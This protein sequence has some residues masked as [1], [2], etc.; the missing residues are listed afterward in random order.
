MRHL[1]IALTFMLPGKLFSQWITLSSG[2][3]ENLRSIYFINSETGYT[4]GEYGKMYRTVNGGNSWDTINT[5][6]NRDINSVYFFNESEGIACANEGIIIRTANAGTNWISVS[7]GVTGNLYSVSF[8]DTRGVCAGAD[9]TLLYST[10]SGLSWTIAKNGFFVIYYAAEMFSKSISYAAGVNT[11]FQPFVAKSTNGGANWS[12][13]NFYL[14]G[15][16]GDLYDINFIN[17]YTGFAPSGVF[18]GQGGIS[19]TTDGG[20]SWSTQLFE[21]QLYSIDFAGPNTGYCV[22]LQG[23]ILKTT[24]GGLTW[25]SQSGTSGTLRSVIF[26]DSLT[27]Y[28]AGDLGVI[29]K[30]TNG[31]LTAVS[32]P[33]EFAPGKYSLKQNYP[34]PFNPETNISFQLPVQKFVS[35]KVYNSLGKE[36]AVLINGNMT[37]GDH[38][39]SF[40]GDNL[41][42]GIYYYRFVAGNYTEVRK[43]IL[44][45]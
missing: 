23:L 11:I 32:D 12:F 14:N 33:D 8:S 25:G 15:N 35:L 44:I 6:I 19:R 27:G 22:G 45:K 3:V 36:I 40:K 7:S 31:G 21:R 39:V 13:N 28:A 2:T 20:G 37:A 4:A 18:N 10:N 34:N 29:I 30:T 26:T 16:E 38:I 17:E 42:G 24:N 41:A 43:M 1:L 5:G 9:G